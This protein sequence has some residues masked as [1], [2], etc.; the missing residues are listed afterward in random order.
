VGQ[1]GHL[2]V[3]AHSVYASIVTLHGEHDLTSTPQLER[4]FEE[5][6]ARTRILVDLSHCI[7]VD[8]TVIK[9]LLRASQTLAAQ[10]GQLSLVIS[11]DRHQAVRRLC[12]LMRLD[13]LM[14]T[15]ETRAAAVGQID[16]P[17][18]TTD[19]PASARLGALSET[20]DRSLIETDKRRAA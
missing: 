17:H 4:T 3:E 1:H 12:E 11:A 10:G 8:S 18:P 14:P 2:E 5:T 20:I 7:F 13:Q 15:Y 19:V 9:T 6:G 16:S